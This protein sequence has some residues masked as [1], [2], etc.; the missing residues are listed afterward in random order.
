ML[1]GQRD[2]PLQD[3]GRRVVIRDTT[4]GLV[5]VVAMSC[6]VDIDLYPQVTP[7]ACGTQQTVA[8]AHEQR[9]TNN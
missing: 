9:R 1:G 5:G 2:G 4:G 6:P 3:R 7:E 8:T